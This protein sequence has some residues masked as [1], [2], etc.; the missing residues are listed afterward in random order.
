MINDSVK[1]ELRPRLIEYVSQITTPSRKAGK[2]MFVCPL[3]GSG[4]HGGRNSD[5]AF[6]VTGAV[7]IHVNQEDLLKAITEL[8][9]MKPARHGGT[10]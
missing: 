5:G 7:S 3:C 10:F 4:S 1:E 8:L 2:N 9:P 6:H